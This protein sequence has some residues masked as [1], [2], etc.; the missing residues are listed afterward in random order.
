MK[1]K[2]V[3]ILSACLAFLLGGMLTACAPDA[4]ETKEGEVYRTSVVEVNYI[5]SKN[6]DCN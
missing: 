1:R 2:L 4:P 5:A 3:G 6:I